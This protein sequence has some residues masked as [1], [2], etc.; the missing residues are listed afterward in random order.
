MSFAVWKFP[1]ILSPDQV[2]R[3]PAGSRIL[4]AQEQLRELCIWAMVD[5]D[6][7]ESL[8]RIAI[9]GT[10]HKTDPAGLIY[11]STVQAADGNLVWH[12]FERV[13]NNKTKPT[14]TWTD[15]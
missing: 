10:G 8:R 3:M 13:W 2:I 15:W 6:G 5:C 7:P 1:L 4:T 11:I 14:P 12:I 9:L